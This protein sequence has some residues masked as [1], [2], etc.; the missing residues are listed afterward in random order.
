MKKSMLDVAYELLLAN[1]GPMSF[2]DM[3]T[4]VAEKENMS[5]DEKNAKMSQF[6][7]NLSIDGRFVVLADNCWDLRERVPFEK[8][9][10]DMNDAYNDIE[11]E[12]D[13]EEDEKDE[14]ESEDG[15]EKAKELGE[16]DVGT[17]AEDNYSEEADESQED[18]KAEAVKKELGV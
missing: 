15:E 11:E 3:L 17:A 1:K 7:T 4:K 18:D 2:F 12:A 10:I 16:D 14:G 6:Y 5:D 13:E 9:H 8:V